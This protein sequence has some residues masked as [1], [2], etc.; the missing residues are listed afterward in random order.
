MKARTL[1]LLML[2]ILIASMLAA[3]GTPATDAPAADAPAAEAPA[4]EAPAEAPAADLPEVPRNRTLIIMAGGPNTYALYNNQNPFIPS[5]GGAFHEGTLPATKEPLIQFNVLTGEYENWLTESWEYNDDNTEITLHLREGVKWS[6][7]EDFNADDVVFT[8][9]LL[10]AHVDTMTHLADMPAYFQEAIK[11]DDLTVTVVLKSPNPAYWATTLSTNHGPVMLPEHIW[12]DKDPLEYADFDIAAGYPVGTGP[13]K[14]VFASPEQ[15]VFD[16]RTDWWAAETGF[17]ELPKVERIIYLPNQDESQ[18]AQLLIQNQ[19]DMAPIM[20]VSTLQAVFAQNP[21]VI[22]FTGTESPYGYLDWCPLDL[23]MND[24][25]APYNDKDIRWAI[26]HAIDREKLVALAES[27]AGV[28]ALHQFTPYGWFAPF[29]EALQPVFEKYGLTTTAD[30]AKTDELMTAK[31]WTKNA[32]GF[33]ADASG[34]T[35]D[36]NIYVPDHWLEAYGPPLTQQLID[37]GFNATFDTS[38]GLATGVQTGEQILSLGCKGPSGVLGMDPY[39]MLAVYSGDYYKPTGDPAPIAWATSRW[40]NAEYDALIK[41][42]APL[43]ADDPAMM[44]LFVQA[45]DIWVSEMPDIYFGQLIIRYPMSTEYWT[46]WPDQN[47]PYGFPHSWQ[48]ELEKTFIN[49]QPTQ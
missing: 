20:Q 21:K 14:L 38:P 2:S 25:V 46:G 29:E 44:D 22:T 36:M 24:D 49:L 37:A 4:A 35:F 45:M 48:E 40:K 3:C 9:N 32:D 18:A 42:I 47:N 11:V 8:M 41:Q 33:W 13:Y 34:A 5:Q 26:S 12:K 28:P 31:G 16:L 1:Q 19:I 43:K 7:G 30:L 27:G 6:D 23:N 15:K 10:G 39:F 17:K